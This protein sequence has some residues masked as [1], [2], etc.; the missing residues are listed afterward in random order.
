MYYLIYG[1]I[2]QFAYHADAVSAASA[3]RRLLTAGYS[4]IMVQDIGYKYVAEILCL[5]DVE[6]VFQC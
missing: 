6:E 4:R 3:C 1:I 5:S 2:P